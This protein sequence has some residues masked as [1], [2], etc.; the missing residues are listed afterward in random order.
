MLPI[1]DVNPGDISCII[2]MLIFIIKQAT[3]QNITAPVLTLYQPLWIKTNEIKYVKNMSIALILWCFH[4]VTSYCGSI[5][6]LIEPS[7]LSEAQKTSFGDVTVKHIASG[8]AY[9]FSK[10][11]RVHFLIEA[12]IMRLLMNPFF[13]HIRRCWSKWRQN[14]QNGQWRNNIF[15]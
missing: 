3:E 13:S 7:G 6:T 2:S 5:G 4:K 1:I 15:W 10:A 12:T 11:L 14:K 9:C 8:K